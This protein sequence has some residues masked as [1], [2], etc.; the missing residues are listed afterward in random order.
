MCH[1]HT[2]HPFLAGGWKEAPRAQSKTQAPPDLLASIS[3]SHETRLHRLPIVNHLEAIRSPGWQY[4][5]LFMSVPARSPQISVL[6]LNLCSYEALLMSCPAPFF[7]LIPT[8]ETLSSIR[9]ASCFMSK[10]HGMLSLL[11]PLPFLV[12]WKS[13]SS[14]KI[15]CP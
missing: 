4:F 3:G 8:P 2:D 9:N 7:H 10:I 5:P 13:S 1:K 6:Y 11:F 14:L 15:L 12:K